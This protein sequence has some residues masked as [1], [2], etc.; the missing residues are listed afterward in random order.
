MENIVQAA[1]DMQECNCKKNNEKEVFICLC[2][3][4]SNH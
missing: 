1:A 2:T 3:D 4:C